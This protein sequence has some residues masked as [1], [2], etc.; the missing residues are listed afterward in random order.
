MSFRD[1]FSKQAI[2]Y[3]RFR[4]GYPAALYEFL[5][6]ISPGQSAALDCATGN[7]QA[8]IGLAK[9]FSSVLATDASPEQIGGATP[10]D[11]ITYVQALAECTPTPD[12]VFDIV[13]AAA[14]LHWFDF[15][16]FYK[17]VRRISRP[18]GVLAAWSYYMFESEAAIDGV[19]SYFADEFTG[20][21]WPERMHLNQGRYRDIPFP[22]DRIEAPAFFAEATWPME[23]VLGFASTWSSTQR[24]R[25]Q[26]GSDPLDEI[27]EDLKRAWGDPKREIQLRWPLHMLVGRVE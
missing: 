18:G 15:D 10:N 6:D 26:T 27:R 19:M 4:P 21:Y 3:A 17:E 20:A 23:R 13:V 11:R 2:D 16:R 22:F 14:G 25:E 1:H 8:A 9:Y 24:Y 7:G 12:H 5:A